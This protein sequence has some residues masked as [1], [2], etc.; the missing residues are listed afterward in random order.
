LTRTLLWA[1]PLGLLGA[2]FAVPALEALWTSLHRVWRQ[3]PGA[4]PFVGLENYAGLLGS[5]R[6]WAAVGHTAV[7][8]A[9]SVALELVLGLGLALLMHRAPGR[10]RGAM[11]GAALL[12]WALPTVVAGLLWAWILHDRY[13]ALN[14]LLADLGLVGAPLVW[15]GEPGLAM[16]GIIGADV[17]KTTPYVALIALAG[18][19]TIDRSVYEAGSLDGAT[20]LRAFT[21]LTLPLLRPA[22][23]VALLFRTVDAL[24]IFDLVFV[25]TRGGPGGS[26]ETVSVLAY[27]ILF[28]ELDVGRGSAMGILTLAGSAAVAGA[29]LRLLR[30]SDA[31]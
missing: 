5:D 3:R 29:Y 11:R 20:G 1:P 13:G 4:A 12:P 28:Q 23:L 24:R 16:A 2:V 10:W 7:F 14:H 30:W 15:L 17:W 6:F 9:S 8:A 21:R 19:G 18:L 31:P 22:L 25:L 27:H 26:T